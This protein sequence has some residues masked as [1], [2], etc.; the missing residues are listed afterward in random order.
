MVTLADLIMLTLYA[1]LSINIYKNRD[2]PNLD[3][4]NAP[5]LNIPLRVIFVVVSFSLIVRILYLASNVV[6]F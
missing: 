1:L 2:A 6:L 4:N 3:K 5:T